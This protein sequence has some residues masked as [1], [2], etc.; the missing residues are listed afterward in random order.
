MRKYK[1]DLHNHTPFIPTDYKGSLETSGRDIVEAAIGAGIDV[2]AI[3]DHFTVGFYR[4][5]CSAAEEVYSDTGKKLLVIPGCEL[6]ITWFGE[7][8][9]LITL[10]PLRNAEDLFEELMEYLRVGQADRVLENLPMITVEVNP[11]S[12]AA[13]IRDL[14]GICHV[15][16]V[17]R[18]FGNYRLMDR[19]IIDQLIKEA[20]ISAIEVIEARNS[21]IL[22]GRTNGIKHISSSDSHSTEEIGRR[23]TELFME[24]LSFES[25]KTALSEAKLGEGEPT[26]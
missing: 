6:K 12:V 9:H 7:E 1:I 26:F 4:I 20:P 19:P 10:F 13:K 23:Y 8:V 16:H 24:N 15:A 18:F 14:G 11:A 22:K 21:K 25:L 5:I 3:S 17:D 2:L